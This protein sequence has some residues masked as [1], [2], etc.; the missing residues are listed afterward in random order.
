M[1][2]FILVDLVFS[3]SVVVVAGSAEAHEAG[4]D[5]VRAAVELPG[6]GRRGRRE[7]RSQKLRHPTDRYKCASNVHALYGSQA[8]YP[9][10]QSV[11]IFL[12]D[13]KICSLVRYKNRKFDS[14]DDG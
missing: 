13:Q 14:I 2:V 9:Q 1:Y 10:C 8:F 5:I 4:L 3:Y 12:L 11:L 6:A 7:V